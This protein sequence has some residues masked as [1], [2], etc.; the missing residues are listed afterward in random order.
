MHKYLNAKIKH[1]I[2]SSVRWAETNP[3]LL[4]GEI[5]IEQDTGY[6][7]AGDGS[8]RWT[9][10]DYLGTPDSIEVRGEQGAKPFIELT[11]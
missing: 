6:A 2:G 4:A 5:G 7:K 10:L 9:D 1:R 3:I 8:T 11:D